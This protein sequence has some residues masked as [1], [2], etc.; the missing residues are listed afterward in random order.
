MPAASHVASPAAKSAPA[1]ALEKLGLV[2][3]IDLALHLPLR[4]EDETRITP[5]IEARDGQTVQVQGRVTDC[6]VEGGFKGRGR[7]QL[8]VTLADGTDELALRFLNFYPS[9]QKTMA[10]GALLRV[11]GELRGGFVGREMVHP[12]VKVVQDDTPMPQALT[13]V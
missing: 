7:R 9:Q 1:R 2:R 12:V 13:P 11:R 4:Y 3:D 6:R 10:P 5:L 8:I